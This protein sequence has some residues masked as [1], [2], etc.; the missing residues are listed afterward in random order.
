M[1]EFAYVCARGAP[2][3]R[4]QKVKAS[5]CN[6]RRAKDVF[7]DALRCVCAVESSWRRGCV[8]LHGEFR[9]RN[10]NTITCSAVKWVSSDVAINVA[11]AAP[12]ARYSP[13]ITMSTECKMSKSITADALTRFP[14]ANFPAK[15]AHRFPYSVLTGL[16]P[17]HTAP[18]SRLDT[19]LPAKL[20]ASGAFRRSDIRRGPSLSRL[21]R[22][23]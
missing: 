14:S 23:R 7:T 18:S 3:N 8:L 19:I 15:R 11:R 6:F 10:E 12:P 2:S 17:P 4:A 16:L 5:N 9:K 21:V 1:R 13:D 20:Q 22:P